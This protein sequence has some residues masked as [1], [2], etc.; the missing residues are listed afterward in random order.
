MLTQADN[1]QCYFETTVEHEISS[2]TIYAII[3]KFLYDF[4]TLT[5]QSCDKKQNKNIRQ[6][7]DCLVLI[8]LESDQE[9][10]GIDYTNLS[11][12]FLSW[13]IL[14]SSLSNWLCLR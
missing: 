4:I 14:Q 13:Y 2:S 1:K 9:K 11:Y 7:T 12:N 3:L 5:V 10:N 6:G 8:T